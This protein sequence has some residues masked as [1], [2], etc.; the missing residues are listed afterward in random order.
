MLLLWPRRLS[1]YETRM[2]Q[3]IDQRGQLLQECSASLSIR[4]HVYVHLMVWLF[5]NGMIRNSD[6]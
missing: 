2:L 4:R 6:G 1:S 5:G 3:G